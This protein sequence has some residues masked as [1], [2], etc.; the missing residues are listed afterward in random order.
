[1]EGHQPQYSWKMLAL[2]VLGGAGL[3]LFAVGVTGNTASWLFIA[4]GSGAVVISL[5]GVWILQAQQFKAASK[6]RRPKRDSD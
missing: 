6:T 1:M 4:S 3:G 5:L 2:L